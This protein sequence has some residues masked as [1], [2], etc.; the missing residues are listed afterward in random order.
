MRHV[1]CVGM[2]LRIGIIY[3]SL[4][5]LLERFG[6]LCCREI[7]S[8]IFAGLGIRSCRRLSTEVKVLS[9]VAREGKFVFFNRKQRLL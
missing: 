1:C 8:I 4:V 2:L 6:V 5:A 7:N 3:S 9:L